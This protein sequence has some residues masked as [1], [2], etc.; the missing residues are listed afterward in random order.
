MQNIPSQISGRMLLLN[1][2]STLPVMCEVV[3]RILRQDSQYKK[4]NIFII[5]WL[6]LHLKKWRLH[7]L[8]K[9]V[10]TWSQYNCLTDIRL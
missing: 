7:F 1:M 8:S 5:I 9:D 6:Y 2:S 3:Y 10:V 4:E